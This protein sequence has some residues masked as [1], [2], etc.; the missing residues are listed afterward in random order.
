M[1]LP[2]ERGAAALWDA[3]RSSVVDRRRLEVLYVDDLIET[4]RERGREMSPALVLERHTVEGSW[5]HAALTIF[6]RV[7]DHAEC[8]YAVEDLIWNEDP[9]AAFGIDGAVTYTWLRIRE[10]VEALP[11]EL[12]V[13]CNP[14][15]SGATRVALWS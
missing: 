4:L 3:P 8:L 2:M 14:D 15:D 10:L 9:I 12:P 5:P 6:F 13:E 11:Y 7:P 1:L